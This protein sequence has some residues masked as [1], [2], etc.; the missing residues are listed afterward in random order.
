M[1]ASLLLSAT[2]AASSVPKTTAEKLALAIAASQG[3]QNVSVYVGTLPPDAHF[4]APLP[5]FALL[6]SVVDT[7]P[8]GAVQ[9]TTVY[10]EMP[11]ETALKGYVSELTRRHWKSTNVF[12]RA[13]E[14]MTARGGFVV[15][16]PPQIPRTDLFCGAA[17]Q[18]VMLQQNKFAHSLAVSLAGGRQSVAMC[19]AMTMMSAMPS[20]PPPPPLPDLKSPPGITMQE[21]PTAGM[22]E[23]FNATTRARLTGSQTLA[24]IGSAFA[25]Q[26]TAAGWSADPVAQTPALY[27]QGFRF[28]SR[29]HHYRTILVIAAADRPQTYDAS[30]DM[31]DLDAKDEPGNFESR[32]IMH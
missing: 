8:L 15:N 5:R 7:G 18:A 11:D 14:E 31:R 12:Q 25:S 20:P 13:Q 10:Y 24:N 2:I 1:F 3:K 32:I 30:L 9:A 6:G 22:F 27:A 4:A 29:G 21:A 16:P 28:T 23:D 26:L 19:A 17:G